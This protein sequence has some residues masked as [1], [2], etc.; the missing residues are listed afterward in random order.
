MMIVTAM[1][2]LVVVMVVIAGDDEDGDKDGDDDDKEK[3]ERGRE[4]GSAMS[5]LSVCS[6]TQIPVNTHLLSFFI[7]HKH[8]Q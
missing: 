5:C 2:A 8:V 6:I 1:M 3:E 7:F 4:K